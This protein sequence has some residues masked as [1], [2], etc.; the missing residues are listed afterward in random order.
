MTGE[1]KLSTRNKL[2]TG[3]A[4]VAVGSLLNGGKGFNASAIFKSCGGSKDFLVEH[5][6]LDACVKTTLLWPIAAPREEAAQ[7]G[8][9]EGGTEEEDE[10]KVLLVVRKSINV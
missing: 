9:Q 5:S 6:K 7:G 8:S 1:C 10:V 2:Q 4:A 3:V